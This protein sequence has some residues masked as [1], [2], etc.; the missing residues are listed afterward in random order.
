MAKPLL[1]G[2]MEIGRVYN[3][4]AS[5]ISNNWV[6]KGILSY[7]DAVIVSGKPYWPGG[8]VVALALPPG[9]RGRQ[10]DERELAALEAEQGAGVRPM[11]KGE[12][13][14]LV[15]AQEYAELFGVTQV[16]VGQAARGG[17]GQLPEADYILSGSNL[18]LLDTVLDSAEV[19]MQ[20]SR[21]GLWVLRDEVAAALREGRYE[22]PGSFLSQR[23]N[24][25]QSA[26]EGA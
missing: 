23:G 17:A 3:I 12:L 5:A 21:K 1:C 26:S 9:S 16:A 2:R 22:G 18:W 20:K 14:P 7:E 19:T 11:K 24:K 15:G 25:A 4:G 10:L 6:Y 13:P 8:L